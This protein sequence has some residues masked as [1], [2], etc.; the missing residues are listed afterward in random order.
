MEHGVRSATRGRDQG[1]LPGRSSLCAPLTRSSVVWL[2]GPSGWL[3]FLRFFTAP[4]EP[5]Y[6]SRA[7]F[8]LVPHGPVPRSFFAPAARLG[9]GSVE[10]LEDASSSSNPPVLESELYVSLPSCHGLLYFPV[11]LFP[12]SRGRSDTVRR[13]LSYSSGFPVPDAFLDNFF[14]PCLFTLL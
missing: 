8:G 2:R 5:C 6:A 1:A 3:P 14:F 11:I 9:H 4:G 7:G 13:S 12:F 10:C